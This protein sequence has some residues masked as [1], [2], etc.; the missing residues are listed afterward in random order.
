MVIK[1]SKGAIIHQQ[2]IPA[3]RRLE[4]VWTFPPGLDLPFFA[5]AVVGHREAAPKVN[6]HLALLNS[7]FA[8]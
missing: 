5:L 3:G 2:T 4:H 1:V 6:P 8:A 7:G